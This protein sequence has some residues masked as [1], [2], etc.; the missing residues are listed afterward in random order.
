MK[1]YLR[2]TVFV[3][4]IQFT[5]NN[6]PDSDQMRRIVDWVKSLGKMA[7]HDGTDIFIFNNEGTETRFSVGDWIVYDSGEFS[8]DSDPNCIKCLNGGSFRKIH[9]CVFSKMF[10]E[11]SHSW[12]PIGDSN[13]DQC[14]FCGDT[15]SSELPYFE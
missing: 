15:R 9:M 13:A 1:R 5:T 6:E 11:C 4:A 2:K 10:E 3:E 8:L 14:L 7:R 12:E